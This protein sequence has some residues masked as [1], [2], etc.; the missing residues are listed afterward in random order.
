MFNKVVAITFFTATALLAIVAICIMKRLIRHASDR[1]RSITNKPRFMWILH[2]LAC[3]FIFLP[4]V[5]MPIFVDPV[6]SAISEALTLAAAL[7]GYFHV[8]TRDR[9][10]ALIVVVVSTAMWI[11]YWPFE[12]QMHLW[13]RTVQG[14]IRMALESYLHCATTQQSC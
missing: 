13:A 14:P 2:I 8:P 3:Y 11:C 10:G 1:G 7:Y 6:A 12:H 5:M 4:V 9:P